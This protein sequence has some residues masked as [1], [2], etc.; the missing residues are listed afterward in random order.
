MANKRKSYLVDKGS[1][2]TGTGT[3]PPKA[4][5]G[6]EV[7]WSKE[8]EYAIGESAL[9]SLYVVSNNTLNVCFIYFA[10]FQIN[11]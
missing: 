3:T 2:A 11:V 4:K 9:M 10:K 6:T 8:F 5:I 1:G 7:F